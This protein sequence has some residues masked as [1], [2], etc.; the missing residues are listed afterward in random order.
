MQ[1]LPCHS[2][3]HWFWLSHAR[4]SFGWH[5][6]ARW[7]DC[8]L[9]DVRISTFHQALPSPLGHWHRVGLHSHAQSGRIFCRPNNRAQTILPH[10]SHLLR[11]CKQFFQM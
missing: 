6:R 5:A 4:G 10:V 2:D 3:C 8:S 7:E 1:A 11:G 9:G